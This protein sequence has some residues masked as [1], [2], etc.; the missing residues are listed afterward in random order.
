M[1]QREGELEVRVGAGGEIPEPLG[2]GQGKG[3]RR[4]STS[5]K[6]NISD[7]NEAPKVLICWIK[8]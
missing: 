6:F 4:G 3:G 1:R 2:R 8:T 5:S 7:G